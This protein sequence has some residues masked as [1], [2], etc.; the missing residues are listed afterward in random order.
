VKASALAAVAVLVLVAAGLAWG[1]AQRSGPA[2]NDTSGTGHSELANHLAEQAHVAVLQSSLALLPS[3]S[4][5]GAALFLFATPRQ[6]TQAEGTAVRDFAQRGGTVVVAT[7]GGHANLWLDRLGGVLNGLPPSLPPNATAKGCLPTLFEVD[8]HRQAAC[9][10]SPT[11]L[12]DQSQQ[13]VDGRAVVG[14]LLVPVGLDLDGDGNLGLGD[15]PPA[16]Y[17]VSYQW[18]L[19]AGKVILVSDGDLWTNSAVLETPDNLGLA[20]LLAG[21]ASTLYLDSTSHPDG[22]TDAV[23][24]GVG[25]AAADPA[26]LPGAA[27]L[28]ALAA[29]AGALA[30]QRRHH[31]WRLHEQDLASTPPHVLAEATALLRASLGAAPAPTPSQ[32]PPS[33]E[34]TP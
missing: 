30:L 34:T 7:D 22:A 28:L 16:T 29:L 2:W 27:L 18:T 15:Q 21:T 9:L 5:P 11:V 24:A 12:A 20:S 4:G 10:P 8:G 19:G 17:P 23:A 13:V 31:P 26:S 1:A 6:P 32:S 33:V 14:R 25:A 3:D